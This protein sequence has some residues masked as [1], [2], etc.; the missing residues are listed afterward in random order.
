MS[1]PTSSRGAAA[2]WGLNLYAAIGLL[3][4]FVPI[5]WIVWFSFNEPKG[6]YNIVW[7]RFTLENWSDPFSNESLTDAFAQSLKIAAISTAIATLLG[8]MIAV[9][10]S[11]YSFKGSSGLNLFLVLPLTTPEI[12]LGSSLATLFL[13][14]D[15]TRGFTTV[16]IAHIMFQVSFVAL[17]VRARVRGFDWTLEQAAQDLGASPMRTFWKVTFPLILPGILAAALLS[18]ALSIDDFIITLFTAGSLSTFPLYINGSFRVQFPPQAN[19]LATMI[20]LASVSLLLIG[21]I[22]S[23]RRGVVGS[24]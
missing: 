23:S 2:R 17:T 9:A 19:V 8:S 12:V 3:Y 7:Q 21:V 13:D 15:V 5:A 16:V 24:S 18:F 6:R 11:R 1:A 10:L 4:L 14:W 20:L 22:R